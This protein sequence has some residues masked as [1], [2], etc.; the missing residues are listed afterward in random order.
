MKPT[1]FR[2]WLVMQ[3]QNAYERHCIAYALFIEDDPWCWEYRLIH[4]E[5][6]E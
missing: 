2:R 1:A 5:E 3:A 4:G 6:G